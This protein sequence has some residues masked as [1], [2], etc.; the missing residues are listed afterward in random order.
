MT[1]DRQS[2]NKATLAKQ[3]LDQAILDQA[4]LQERAK[5]LAIPLA[6]H[7]VQNTIDVV[8]FSIGA[9]KYIIESQYVMEITKL[10]AYTPVP[11]TP[12]FVVGVTNIRGVVLALIDL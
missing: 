2:T 12:S 5:R 3:T 1:G 10:R 11:G 8:T 7:T 4:I 6:D 9:E